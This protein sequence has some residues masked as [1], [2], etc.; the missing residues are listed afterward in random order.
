VG[1]PLVTALREVLAAAA[2]PVVAKE[3]NAVVRAVKRHE[4]DPEKLV[5]WIRT[6][7][8]AQVE[9][10]GQMLL[11]PVKALDV[12]LGGE[13]GVE[14]RLAKALKTWGEA[15]VQRALT[16]ERAGALIRI[17]SN[18]VEDHVRELAEVGERVAEG[19]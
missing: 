10:A 4:R 7:Y 16:Q 11:P 12:A 19:E 3:R 14:A 8:A 18:H 15:C 6:F 2:R 17:V 9:Y 1:S 5:E 13:E